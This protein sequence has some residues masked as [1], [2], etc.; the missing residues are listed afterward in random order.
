MEK[1]CAVLFLFQTVLSTREREV[2]NRNLCVKSGKF[3]S[4]CVYVCCSIWQFAI[5]NKMGKVLPIAQRTIVG[6]NN[7]ASLFQPFPYNML[8]VLTSVLAS[9]LALS[10]AICCHE[11]FQ[12]FESTNERSHDLISQTTDTKI[13]ITNINII[14]SRKMKIK[15]W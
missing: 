6:P 8:E 5:P 15:T 7:N 9:L 3:T 10:G 11:T 12:S 1:A 2:S 13:L 14:I 4:G